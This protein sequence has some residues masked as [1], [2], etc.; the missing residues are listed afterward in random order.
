M[1]Y[2]VS[3]NWDGGD[4]E[5]LA[6]RCGDESEA[7]EKFCKRWP[8]ACD[9]ADMHVHCVFLH[10]TI[11]AAKEFSA[12]YGGEI[13]EIDDEYLDIQKDPYEGEL[14]VKDMIDSEYVNK[15]K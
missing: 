9:A 15:S 8:E 14:Y 7:I 6:I 2:H 3:K 13:L 5:S 12:T 10:S 4:L 11:E 1:K